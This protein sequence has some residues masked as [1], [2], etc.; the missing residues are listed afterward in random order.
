MS[1]QRT[2]SFAHT[3]GEYRISGSR[4]TTP[5]GTDDLLIV[6]G[7]SDTLSPIL[8][9]VHSDGGRL[10]VRANAALFANARGMLNILSDI[11][12]VYDDDDNPP[13]WVDDARDVLARARGE[14][15]TYGPQ[16]AP[17]DYRIA[18]RPGNP[19]WHGM[20]DWFDKAAEGGK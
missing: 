8:C 12:G 9:T 19:N 15:P 17:D 16:A 18:N 11:V 14:A 1:N 13:G 20:G 5:Q 6:H 10:P 4:M 2:D 3:P 7:D